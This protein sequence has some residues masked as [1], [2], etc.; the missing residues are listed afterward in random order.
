MKKIKTNQKVQKKAPMSKGTKAILYA[1]G[2][3][4][5]LAIIILVWIESDSGKITVSNKSGRK[6]EYVEAYFVDAEGLVSDDVMLFD[7]L[8]NGGKF[9]LSLDKI[10]LVGREANL[11]INFK[12]EDNEELFI[13]AGYFNDHFQGKIKVDFTQAE[14]DKVLLKV[15][16]TPGLLP[17]PQIICDEEHIVNLEEG[18]V[19]E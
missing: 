13:D 15:K 4:L 10:D 2:G 12:F 16:A 18:Y 7:N 5:L 17:S 14:D 1:L 11:E 9:V 3:V 19:E 8:E 6:I